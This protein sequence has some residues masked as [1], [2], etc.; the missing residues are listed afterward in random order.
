MLDKHFL[1]GL[2]GQRRVDALLHHAH[3]R[4]ECRLERAICPA[5]LIKD[6]EHALGKR[7]DG[8]LKLLDGVLPLLDVGLVVG[9][10]GLQHFHQFCRCRDILVEHHAT[11]LIQDSPARLPEQDVRIG[12]A[13]GKLPLH[14]DGKIVLAILG[15]PE[16]PC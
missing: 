16:A 1:H 13:V 5:L 15:F 6:L 14:L 10:E 11:V 9:E 12:I 2:D 8:I 7:R 3:E 4:I